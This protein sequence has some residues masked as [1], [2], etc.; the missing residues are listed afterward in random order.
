LCFDLSS[1]HSALDYLLAIKALKPAA[2]ESTK[3]HL[4]IHLRCV[5]GM[6]QDICLAGASPDHCVDSPKGKSP[7]A[8]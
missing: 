5:Y 3:N 7:N 4:L 1:F 2:D 6:P 8:E